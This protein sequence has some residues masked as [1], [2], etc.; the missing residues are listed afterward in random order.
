MFLAV[1]T[2]NS[3]GTVGSWG[4]SGNGRVMKK[5]VNKQSFTEVFPEIKWINIPAF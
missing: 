4:R 1:T 5:K 2:R 3:A